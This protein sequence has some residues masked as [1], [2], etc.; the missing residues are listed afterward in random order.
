M[1]HFMYVIN[2]ITSIYYVLFFSSFSLARLLDVCHKFVT[3][4]MET[5]DTV[6]A[7]AIGVLATIFLAS[8]VGLIVVCKQKYCKKPDLITIQH[9]DTQ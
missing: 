5:M 9:K 8:L 4:L 2:I 7:I 1:F 3:I 6:V